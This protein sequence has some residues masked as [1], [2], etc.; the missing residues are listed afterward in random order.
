MDT[1][2]E[3]L[4]FAL[5][6]AKAEHDVRIWFA[7]GSPA[8]LGAGFKQIKIVEQWLASARWADLIVPTGNHLYLPKLQQ[9][10]R[11]GMHVFGPSI[12]SAKLEI[13][14]AFGMQFFQAHGI[15]VPEFK[16]FK[17]LADAEAHVYQTERAYVFKTLGDED[18]K[19]LSYVGKTPADLIARLQRWQRM[20]LGAKGPFM[21][22]EKVDGVE[23]GVSRWMGEAGFVGPYNENFEFKKLM[24]GNAGPN[25]G[26]AGT[27]MKYVE[28]SKLG[29]S[30]LAPLEQSLV[31]LGH[32]GDIDVNCII[33][34][35]GRAWPLEFTMRLG[36][37]AFNIQLA[38]TA[39][40]PVQWMLDACE[41]KDTLKVRWSTACGVV[42]AQPSYP[43]HAK[44]PEELVDVP[45]YGVSPENENYLYPQAVKRA[46]LPDMKDGKLTERDIWASAG[47]YLLV[48]TGTGKTVRQAATRAY[49]TLHD[50]YVPDMIYRDD[51]GE[52]LEE[53]LPKLHEHGYAQEFEYE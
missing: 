45:I 26:E 39:G 44:P 1:V 20:D 7:K 18:D 27:V 34:E 37:P 33:D 46:V 6:A 3:G 16:E 51:I 13:K 2:G 36:W 19:S 21:L 24:S 47:D 30:V 48:V 25:C 31:K 43:F 11:A 40:D 52:K 10:R 42:I 23:V 41:G 50:I 49:D 4:A 12:E 35:A 15:E 28:D 9:L 53:E 14:R 5:R 32:L 8:E 22:Q 38:T 29:K 17:T